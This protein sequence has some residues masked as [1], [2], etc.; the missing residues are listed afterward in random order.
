M[1]AWRSGN[2]IFHWCWAGNTSPQV[3]TWTS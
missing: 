2:L 1:N 3:F